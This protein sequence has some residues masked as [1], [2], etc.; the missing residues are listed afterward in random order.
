MLLPAMYMSYTAQGKHGSTVLIS[1]G[2]YICV[3]ISGRGG[4]GGVVT[5]MGLYYFWARTNV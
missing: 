5:L 4:G 1:G 2:V 3:L